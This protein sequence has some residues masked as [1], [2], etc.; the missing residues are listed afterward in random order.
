MTVRSFLDNR[1]QLFCVVLLFDPARL[2]RSHQLALAGS[3]ELLPLNPI[4]EVP[5]LWE[6]DGH[7]QPLRLIYTQEL[8]DPPNSSADLAMRVT[9][10]AR[11]TARLHSFDTNRAQNCC[12]LFFKTLDACQYRLTFGHSVQC[13]V[14]QFSV[15]FCFAQTSLRDPTPPAALANS[16]SAWSPPEQE[17]RAEKPGTAS[18]P[19][20]LAPNHHG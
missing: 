17:L 20:V 14:G 10:P 13:P 2:P 19:G 15:D 18:E 7:L 9:C 4:P 12:W 6:A 16:G 8:V 1:L 3:S 11:N 5:I